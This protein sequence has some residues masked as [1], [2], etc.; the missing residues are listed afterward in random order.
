MD[1]QNQVFKVVE[2]GFH[3]TL[4][5]VSVATE[6]LQNEQKRAQLVSEISEQL[7]QRAQEWEE[8]GEATAT[9]ARQFIEQF[10]NQGAEQTTSSQPSS[11]GSSETVNVSQSGEDAE[12]AADDFPGRLQALTDEVR[13]LREEMAQF[14]S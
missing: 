10:I 9:E 14:R 13:T 3:I 7:N 8:K 1:N 5:A 2:Q 11:S 4:G 6:T 12:P